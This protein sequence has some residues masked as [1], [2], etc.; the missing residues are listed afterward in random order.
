MSDIRE[1]QLELHGPGFWGKISGISLND[2]LHLV[3]IAMVGILIFMVGK[4]DSDR[5]ARYADLQVKLRDMENRDKLAEQQRA[6]VNGALAGLQEE[7]INTTW[8]VIQSESVK[9]NI[10]KR[11]AM[12]RSLRDR[13][14]PDR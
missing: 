6:A 5:E 8:A 14:S 1:P 9:E 4:S 3:I 12:P 10:R 11:L 13:L 2:I 7:Q